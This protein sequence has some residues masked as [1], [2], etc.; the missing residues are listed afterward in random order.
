MPYVREE[1]RGTTGQDIMKMNENFMNIFQKVFGDINYSDVDNLM[2]TAINT[3]WISFQGEGNLDVNYNYTVRFFVPP[4]VKKVNSA[5]FNAIL[6]QYRMDSSVAEDSGG[7]ASG[8]VSLSVAD[9][10]G[11]AGAVT[12]G[13]T[14]SRV[15]EWGGGGVPAPPVP[16]TYLSHDNYSDCVV[17]NI[18][19][20]STPYLYV[21]DI[22]S[23]LGAPI[24]FLAQNNS[25]HMNSNINKFA[26]VDMYHFQHTHEI[27]G[28]SH[29]IAIEPHTH[30]GTTSIVIPPHSH[31][32][33]EGIK[34]SKR[35]AGTTILSVNGT[36]VIV[37]TPDE[38]VKNNIDITEHIRIG[39]W[40]TITATTSGLS[41]I[42]LYGT[43]EVVVKNYN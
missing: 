42:T 38:A 28:H 22:D 11:Y 39:E 21:R 35:Q 40:N 1:I 19:G 6:E 37:L 33:N 3:Q 18:Y 26:L 30:T 23:G 16:L 36:D 34:V 8:D 27:A 17:T 20:D 4:N 32:L 5:S 7:Y 41:R 25:V 14:T 2:K 9:G 15:K 24:V 29:S 10:G 13:S 31:N 12:A 43:V